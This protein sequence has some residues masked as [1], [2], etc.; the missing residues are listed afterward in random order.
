MC[1]LHGDTVI[2]GVIEDGYV[3]VAVHVLEDREAGK[4]SSSG[5]T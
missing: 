3:G 4:G 1:K 5:L 2:G